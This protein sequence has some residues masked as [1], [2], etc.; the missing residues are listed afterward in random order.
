MKL[1]KKSKLKRRP[2]TYR[3]RKSKATTSSGITYLLQHKYPWDNVWRVVLSG[4]KVGPKFAER[5]V[6]EP[7]HIIEMEYRLIKSSN[8]VD[9]EIEMDELLEK[10]K[11]LQIEKKRKKRNE[12]KR[13]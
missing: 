1:K 2:R 4:K 7:I 5:I 10:R 6:D 3:S 8:G 9:K 12:S 13:K 11:A